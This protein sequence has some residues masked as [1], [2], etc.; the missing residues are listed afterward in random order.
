MLNIISHQENVS[1]DNNKYHFTPTRWLEY[2]SQ[3]ITSVGEGVKKFNIHTLVVG[4]WDNPAVLVNSVKVPQTIKP[5][6][7]QWLRK[8]TSRC[9][10]KKKKVNVHIK[11]CTQMF[12]AALS[13]ITKMYKQLKY[14]LPDDG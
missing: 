13:I 14:I 1:K 3:I 4:M 7:T 10:L 11:T 6:A 2:N 9:I 5:G 8:S 12:T